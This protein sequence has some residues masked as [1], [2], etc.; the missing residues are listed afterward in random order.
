MIYR[1]T[2]LSEIEHLNGLSLVCKHRKHNSNQFFL[3]A[4]STS[5]L[6]FRSE[7][8]SS[9]LLIILLATKYVM[10][11]QPEYQVKVL[12]N[13]MSVVIFSCVSGWIRCSG[14]LVSSGIE[15]LIIGTFSFPTKQEAPVSFFW[16]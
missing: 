5:S 12:T 9:K 10:R 1:Q 14:E 4:I 11:A 7:L 6:L 15:L 13:Q 3:F 2:A 16:N 8:V